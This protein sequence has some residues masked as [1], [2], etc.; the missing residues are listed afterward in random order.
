[1]N[2]LKFNTNLKCSG[3]IAKIKPLLDKI[4]EIEQWSV[5][6]N[7]PQRILTVQLKSGQ[8]SLIIKTLQQ[9]G[10]QATLLTE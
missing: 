1:M 8:P 9:A 3:C 10:Y 2:T 6:L 4:P 5:N 7:T